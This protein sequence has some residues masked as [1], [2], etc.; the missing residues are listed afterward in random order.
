M[1]AIYFVREKADPA[2]DMTLTTHDLTPGQRPA[3]HT[4]QTGAQLIEALLPL[5][6]RD[7][8][9]ICDWDLVSG[10]G[11]LSLDDLCIRFPYVSF[12]ITSGSDSLT[13]PQAALRAGAAGFFRND[14][15]IS[16]IRNV[17]DIVIGGE[18]FAVPGHLKP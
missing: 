8:I 13:V 17:L 5:G 14:S 3:T 7:A 9:V 16:L 11:C 18:A 2:L 15:P 10:H 6:S 1:D 12:V 4:L